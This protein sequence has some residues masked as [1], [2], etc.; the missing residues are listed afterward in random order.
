VRYLV[1]CTDYDGTLACAGRVAEET[2]RA[3]AELRQTGRKL[4]LV[5]GRELPDLL[6]VYPHPELFD[7]IVAENGGLLYQPATR[8]EVPLAEPPPLAFVEALRR[9]GVSP[10]SAGRVVVATREPNQGR[11]LETIAELG[12]ELQ[13]T[14]NKGAVMVLPAGVNKATGLVRALEELGLSPRNAVGVGDAENDHAFL[15]SCECAV[16][17]ADALPA[18]REHAD[19]VTAASCS[20]GVAELARRLARDDL[21]DVTPALSRRVAPDS[22]R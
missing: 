10:L 6:R 3:L 15:A 1:L 8:E 17:V 21:R 11:V 12:L 22:R 20:G 19:L 2:D 4:V 5:T 13:I 14:F 16:A 18:I 9:R 7:R